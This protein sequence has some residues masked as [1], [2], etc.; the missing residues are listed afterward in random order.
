MKLCFG[1][2]CPITNGHIGRTC[3]QKKTCTICKQLHTTSLHRGEQNTDIPLK[4]AASKSISSE[5]ISM[6]IVPVR[7]Y[8]KDNPGEEVVTYAMLDN[9][10]T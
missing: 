5:R 2:L 8:H 4:A 10:Y 9:D 3:T 1:C 7:V 6:C